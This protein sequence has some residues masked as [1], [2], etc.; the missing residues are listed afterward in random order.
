MLCSSKAITG[1]IAVRLL[2]LSSGG[3]FPKLKMKGHV[4]ITLYLVFAAGNSPAAL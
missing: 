1:N 2:Q 4:K 3:E